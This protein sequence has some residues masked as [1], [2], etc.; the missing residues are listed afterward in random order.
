MTVLSLPLLKNEIEKPCFLNIAVVL[1]PGPWWLFVRL[2]VSF[3]FRLLEYSIKI[4]CWKIYHFSLFLGTIS[5]RYS[6][7]TF[8]KWCWKAV[9]LNAVVP[10]MFRMDIGLIWVKVFTVRSRVEFRLEIFS[11]RR[12]A[13]SLRPVINT[14]FFVSF[15]E[16]WL[17]FSVREW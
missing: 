12:W 6:L 13:H 3:C 4:Y 14:H 10:A 9:D 17:H 7:L 15:V 5:F 16:E 1:L 11:Q 8:C 2:D